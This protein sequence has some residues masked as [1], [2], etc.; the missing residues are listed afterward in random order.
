MLGTPFPIAHYVNCDKFTMK[1]RIF[2]GIVIVEVEPHYF[3]E[4]VKDV[5]WCSAMQKD[6]KALEANDI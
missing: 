1:H 2:F 6:V 4:A 3:K 5:W